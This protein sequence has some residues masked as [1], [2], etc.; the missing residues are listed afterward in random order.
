MKFKIA[1]L[2]D[3]QVLSI[4]D[5]SVIGYV[6]DIEIDSNDGK[7]ISIIISGKNRGFS[8]LSRGEDIVIP[9]EKID[10]IGNDS[11]LVSFDGYIP[12]AKR[13]RGILSGLFF[14]E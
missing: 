10:V 3:K 14:G 2:K 7:L 12:G 9:F 1:E 8:V 11:I 6:T 4:K 5:A 13:K